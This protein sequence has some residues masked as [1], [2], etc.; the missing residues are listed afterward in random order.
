[1]AGRGLPRSRGGFSADINRSHSDSDSESDTYPYNQSP[2]LNPFQSH[3]LSESNPPIPT[4]PTILSVFTSTASLLSIFTST[5]S[6]MLLPTNGNQQV[7][8]PPRGPEGTPDGG[9]ERSGMSANSNEF[10]APPHRQLRPTA[11]PSSTARLTSPNRTP[12]P[13]QSHSRTHTDSSALQSPS[14]TPNR[15]HECTAPQL[16]P[17][18]EIPPTQPPGRHQNRHG[19]PSLAA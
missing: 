19:Q 10:N 16:R 2:N 18:A 17:T 8:R 14:T 7:Q 3:D 5:A 11:T 9:L 6:L 13:R 15:P 12:I 1:M 4:D